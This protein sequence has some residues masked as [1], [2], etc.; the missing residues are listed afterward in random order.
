MHQVNQNVS[1]NGLRAFKETTFPMQSK[2][3][4]TLIPYT[5]SNGYYHNQNGKSEILVGET[6]TDAGKI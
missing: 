5:L 2:L 4:V 1:V 3:Q 6:K